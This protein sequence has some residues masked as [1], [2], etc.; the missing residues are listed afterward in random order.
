MASQRVT[1]KDVAREAGV[2]I[3]TVSNALNDVDV[4]HPD[5]KRHI[6]SVAEKL[7]YVPNLNGRNL[8]SQAT[9]VIG[10]F[11][12]SI[13]G[14]YYSVLADSVY[15]RCKEYGYEL[16]IFVSDKT[17]TMMS[18]M[19]GRRID[20]AI[21]LNEWIKEEQVN[22]LLENELPIV[23][24]DREMR[25]EN[26]SSVVFDSYHEG[27]LAARYLMKLGHKTFGYIYG[28]ENNFDNLQR[29][30]GFL[31]ILRQADIVV[32]EEYM[33]RGDFDKDTAYNSMK[34]FLQSGK[35]PPE[36]IFAANDQS[37]IGAIEALAEEG[38]GVPE[39]V[40]VMG[41]DDIE[42]ASLVKPSITTIRTSFEKQGILAVNHLVSLIKKEEK[43]TIDVLYGKVISRES[44]AV[45]QSK[46]NIS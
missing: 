17:G 35:K 10:L 2:S 41:C 5:T 18:D 23:F 33:L 36:A 14:A 26:V 39:Q 31:N 21:I 42:M 11:I 46:V 25:G 44:T 24:I 28:V 15:Q 40:S 7:H 32:P 4:L 34:K 45:N 30:K 13:R 22:Q 20:G 3:S 37:A 16:N 43:G 12:T 9:N 19:L 6:L 1:I 29:L 38:I 27:E 8:K